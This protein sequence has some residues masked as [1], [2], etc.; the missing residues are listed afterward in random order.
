MAMEWTMA[1]EMQLRVM[2]KDGLS[3]SQIAS[4]FALDLEP[5]ETVTR[6]MICGKARRLD[7]PRRDVVTCSG[8]RAKPPKRFHKPKPTAPA[9][10]QVLVTFEQLEGHHCRYPV[11]DAEN[12]TQM[13]CGARK[14]PGSP[15]CEH[16]HSICRVAPPKK[17]RRSKKEEAQRSYYFNRFM[18]GMAA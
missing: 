17:Q 10:D 14:K 6:S 15:Y 11:G 13:F 4:K 12:G 9:P 3:V 16:H 2:W 18:P 5:G 7:L 1:R 8:T